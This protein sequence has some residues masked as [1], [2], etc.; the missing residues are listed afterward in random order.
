MTIPFAAAFRRLALAG[1]C[2]ATC[3]LLCARPAAASEGEAQVWGQLMLA[4]A[5]AV[6]DSGQWG[7]GGQ[8]G[9]LAGITDFWSILGGVDASYQFASGDAPSAEILGL[10]AGFRYNLDVFQY[11]P[12]LGL[13]FE[14]FPQGPPDSTG[15]QGP[16]VGAKLSI[17]LDWRYSRNCSAGAM[18]EL[19][20]PMTHPDRF[21]IY[22]TLG[23]NLTY[24]FRL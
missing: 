18:I 17:G 11:V 13:S 5:N 12:Y 16:Q 23:A 19:H 22:S 24:H 20:A 4:N 2:V 10:F 14:D 7:P 15:A 8:I 9:V 1:A 6:G 21:P 3:L